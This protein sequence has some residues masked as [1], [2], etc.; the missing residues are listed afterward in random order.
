[1][2]DPIIPG[3]PDADLLRLKAELGQQIIRSLS[4]TDE[5]KAQ[6]VNILHQKLV[7]TVAALWINNPKMMRSIASVV[8]G[9]FEADAES[10]RNHLVVKAS[11]K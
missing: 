8:A 7:E 10:A 3:I 4:W 1:M 6:L 11:A 2:P 5:Q 9:N